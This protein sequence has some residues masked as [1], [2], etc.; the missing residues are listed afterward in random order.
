MEREG[1]RG[2]SFL[3]PEL[4]LS[5]SASALLRMVEVVE[6]AQLRNSEQAKMDSV[7]SAA[8]WITFGRDQGG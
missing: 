1:D 4:V 8:S 3:S 6:L 7:R 2:R 5:A